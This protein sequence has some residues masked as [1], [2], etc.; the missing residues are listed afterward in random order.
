MAGLA[1]AA[2]IGVMTLPE[3][4]NQPTMENLS[5]DESSEEKDQSN[6]ND[7]NSPEKIALM[8]PSLVGSQSFV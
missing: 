6:A 2:A 5:Q 4:L 1:V 8:W 3:T 7:D